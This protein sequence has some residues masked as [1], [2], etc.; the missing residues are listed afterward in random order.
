MWSWCQQLA[1][2]YTAHE[3]LTRWEMSYR[4]RTN[5]M[6]SPATYFG[7]SPPRKTYSPWHLLPNKIPQSKVGSLLCLPCPCTC[8][9]DTPCML[10]SRG[11]ARIVHRNCEQFRPL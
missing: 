7:I 11:G 2:A 3:L 4:F 5:S 9:A 8:L 6:L 10:R 1:W